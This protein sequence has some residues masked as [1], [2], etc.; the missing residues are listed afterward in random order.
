MA[1]E[2]KTHKVYVDN[3]LKELA[4]QSEGKIIN[5]ATGT[6]VKSII[7]SV[8]SI[9]FYIQTLLKKLYRSLYLRTASGLFLDMLARNYGKERKQ[10]TYAT[11]YIKVTRSRD[12]IEQ[13]L[14]ARTV[15]LTEQDALGEQKKYVLLENI[16]FPI[17]T[18]TAYGLVQAVELG[19]SGNTDDNTILIVQNQNIGIDTV[20]NEED[21]GNGVDSETDEELRARIENYILGLNTGNERNIRDIAL[22][23]EGVIYTFIRDD[24]NIPGIVYLMINNQTGDLDSSIISEV[25]ERLQDERLMGITINVSRSPIKNVTLYIKIKLRSRFVD[26]NITD[27]IKMSVADFINS[28][29]PSKSLRR[30]DLIGHIEKISGVDYI[31][32]ENGNLQLK[33]N[34]SYDDIDNVS[35]NEMVRTSPD[36][37]EIEII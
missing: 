29:Q 4:S 23:V 9:V 19:T 13:V 16:R 21:V 26:Q 20:T 15:F 1:T 6:V 28:L 17:G 25:R 8:F 10:A 33:I 12:D 3:A 7:E 18:F 14:Q 36:L 32:N 37:I 27:K 11:T 35:T 34:N 2:F 5:P 31:I 30:S 22:D 24:K